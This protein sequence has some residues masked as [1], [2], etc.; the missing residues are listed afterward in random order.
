MT[1]KTTVSFYNIEYLGLSIC[2]GELEV[3]N[4]SRGVII[5]SE[6]NS[7]GVFNLEN[8]WHI[9]FSISTTLK[10]YFMCADTVHMF[11]STFSLL[12]HISWMIKGFWETILW[13]NPSN[14]EELFWTFI[15][16]LV[17][18]KNTSLLTMF[19][20]QINIKKKTVE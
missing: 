11:L 3:G 1:S 4:N 15:L 18:A 5:L 2:L 16:I 9:L 10:N 6:T 19:L 20:P 13:S 12:W 14:S 8:L 7:T 17:T